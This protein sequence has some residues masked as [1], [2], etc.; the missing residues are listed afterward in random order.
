MQFNTSQ[1][2][3]RAPCKKYLPPW[4]WT[5]TSLPGVLARIPGSASFFLQVYHNT[6]AH[7]STYDNHTS[8]V[9]WERERHMTTSLI[10]IPP[11]HV[12]RAEMAAVLCHRYTSCVHSHETSVLSYKSVRHT[13]HANPILGMRLPTLKSRLTSSRRRQSVQK[14]RKVNAVIAD[15]TQV[16]ETATDS[17]NT[18]AVREVVI[19][20]GGVA[21]LATALALH[22]WVSCSL[23][24]RSIYYRAIK[25]SASS[26]PS[27]TA[28]L[29]RW[30]NI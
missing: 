21:G 1:C 15:R 23:S 10:N 8:H 24:P 9:I 3:T 26:R 27:S 22:R 18:D 11:A 25:L 7:I 20:G 30:I 16:N 4:H 14:N 13:S 19:V 5:G 29:P 2:V 12:A 17:E 6:H 28:M